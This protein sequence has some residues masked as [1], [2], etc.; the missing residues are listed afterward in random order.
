MRAAAS[1]DEPVAKKGKKVEQEPV[2]ELPSSV[3][4]E[5]TSKQQGENTNTEGQT[6]ASLNTD[7]QSTLT[8]PSSST[9]EQLQELANSLLEV[10]A[11]A[12]ASPT[13]PPSTR[14]ASAAP[15]RDLPLLI[16]I[17]KH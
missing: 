15:S 16:I 17:Q 2:I 8:I 14:A 4:V 9:V 1:E 13:T 11:S 7:G 6:K 10:T 3:F 5:I 12:R